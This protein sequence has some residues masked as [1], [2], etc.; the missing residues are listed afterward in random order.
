VFGVLEVGPDST[1]PDSTVVE[2]SIVVKLLA[3]VATD[4]TVFGSSS[5]SIGVE[6]VCT[7]PPSDNLS[8]SSMTGK[9]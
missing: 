1:V 7:D 4:V 5:I 9:K 3:E 2:E 6:L 8:D